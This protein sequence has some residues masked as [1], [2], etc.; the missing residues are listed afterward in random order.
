[1]FN[2]NSGLVTLVLK[3]FRTD[4]KYTREDVPDL[5]NLRDVVY[6]ILDSENAE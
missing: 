6:K 2:E 5:S 1:M 3:K 4:P